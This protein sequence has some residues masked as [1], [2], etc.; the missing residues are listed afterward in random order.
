MKRLSKKQLGFLMEK[1]ITHRQTDVI[2]ALCNGL[3]NKEIGEELEIREK[4]VKFHLTFIYKLL[5]VKNRAQL[6][7]LMMKVENESDK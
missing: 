5:N 2:G 3:T 7:V 1:K 4:G 6:I